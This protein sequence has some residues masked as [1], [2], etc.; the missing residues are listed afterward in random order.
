MYQYMYIYVFINYTYATL[1]I[2]YVRYKTPQIFKGG[3]KI[4]IESLFS[5]SISV[6]CPVPQEDA[7]HSALKSSGLVD[8]AQ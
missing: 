3:D 4:E 2:Y 5:S 6:N 1:L 7:Q 8:P